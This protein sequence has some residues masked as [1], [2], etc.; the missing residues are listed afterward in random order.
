MNDNF[1]PEILFEDEMILLANKPSGIPVHQTKDPNRPDFT[2]LLETKYGYSSL[3]TVNR[4]DLGTSGIVVLGKD[5]AKNKEIDALLSSAEKEYVF[6]GLGCP[7][8]IEQDHQCFLKDGNKKVAIVR[9]GGKKSITHFSVF[10]IDT[11]RH[12]FLGK[13]R[14]LTGRRHQIRISIADLGYPI[15]GDEVYGKE[16]S[17]TRLFLHSYRMKLFFENGITKE[18][19]C[20]PPQEFRQVFPLLSGVL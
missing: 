14:L 11:E 16:A 17:K 2:R 13:A 5:S 4:L 15:L 19:F 6:I 8:W 9:S 10:K 12:L 7:A 3:R 20:P 1:D 18:V